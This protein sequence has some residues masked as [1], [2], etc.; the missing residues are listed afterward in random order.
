MNLWRAITIGLAVIRVLE[1]IA[2]G[3]QITFTVPFKGRAYLVTLSVVPTLTL[4]SG[5]KM[6]GRTITRLAE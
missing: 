1:Q 4:A 6:Y 3:E 2:A 5:E